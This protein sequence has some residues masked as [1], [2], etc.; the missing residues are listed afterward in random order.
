MTYLEKKLPSG[1]VVALGNGEIVISVRSVPDLSDAEIAQ[2]VRDL[3]ADYA[4]LKHVFSSGDLDGMTVDE[5]KEYV[6]RSAREN[7]TKVVKTDI[8][9]K[10]RSQFAARRLQLELALIE[11]DGYVCQE[12]SCDVQEDLTIDHLV[13]LSRGGSDEL[14][15]LRLLCR[16]HNSMK[17]DRK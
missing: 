13:A 15:N 9:R 2:A 6:V 16:L 4:I 11:R 8:T 5:A 1:H 17:G 14:P 7:R 10:R 3:A 12:P